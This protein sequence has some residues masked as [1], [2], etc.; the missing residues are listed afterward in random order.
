MNKKVIIPGIIGL[1]LL[2]IVTLF[3]VKKPGFPNSGVAETAD[4]H[5]PV[6]RFG[7]PVDSFNIIEGIVKPGQNLG[8]ILTGF[9]VPMSKV[10]QLSRNSEEIF[11]VRKIRSGQKFFLFQS[12]DTVRKACYLVYENNL[13]E[14]VIFGLSNSM[15]I[16]RGEKKVQRM[17]KS[18]SGIIASNLWNTMTD[19]DLNPMLA[20]EL[21][22]IYAWTIDFFG[23]QKGDK[24]RLLYEE[25]FV[26][27][28]STGVGPVHAVE[29]EH[30]GKNYYA[31]RFSQDE[32]FDYFDDKG[33]NLRKAF[34]K[35]PLEFSRI[36]SRFS[37]SRLH[38]VL[39]IRRPHHGVDYA[40]PLG[41]P[42]V[43]IG[44]GTVI[45]KGYQ[46]GSG[47]F[48]KIRH[49]AVYT[50]MY[51]HLSRFGK[52]VSTGSRVQQGEVIGYVGSTGLS[53]GPHLDF[54]V[55]MNGTPI[56]PLK[57]DAPPGDPVKTDYKQDFIHTR[58]SLTVCL[59]SINWHR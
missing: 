59:Y 3:L 57:I 30:M 1:G 45:G 26:D 41:T 54:R 4:L 18:A 19:N 6:M 38:P 7:L 49:N 56:D 2:A 22:K 40:A 33:E 46:G 20:I 14:Y 35:A 47:N 24:F 5:L 12:P 15:S 28:V 42:V 37:G 39:K 11:D 27:T 9:G 36:S 51:L 44:D 13:V 32:G 23:I 48:V 50:T 53:T 43:S 58:D 31:F 52:G 25:Q 10:D 16:S 8:E 55:F 21:S 29:F 17:Q 34:L